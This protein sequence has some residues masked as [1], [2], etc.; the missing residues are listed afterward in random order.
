[1]ELRLHHALPFLIHHYNY[2]SITITLIILKFSYHSYHYDCLNITSEG[3]LSSSRS[4]R[5]ML[6]VLG[7]LTQ[8][9]GIVREL[10][11]PESDS[12]FLKK[13]RDSYNKKHIVML[14]SNTSIISHNK[15]HY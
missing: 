4:D 10:Q 6:T 3:D 12:S 7:A 14:Q 9:L 8:I 5:G 2:A 1:M 11:V 15:N 13:Y